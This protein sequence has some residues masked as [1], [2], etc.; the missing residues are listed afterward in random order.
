MLERADEDLI[1]GPQARAAPGLRD[2]VDRLGGAADKDD[3]ARAAGIDETPYALARALVRG[4]SRLTERMHAAMYVGVRVGLVVLDRAQ[5]RQRALRGCGA[6]QI[7]QRTPVHHGVED[8]KVATHALGVER[9]RRGEGGVCGPQADSAG[10]KGSGN[11]S[12]RRSSIWPRS[13]ANPILATTY[14]RNAH[15]S[16]RCATSGSSP[17]DSR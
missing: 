2:E 15:F 16:S 8:R 13:S 5:H 10:A 14:S 9:R 6:V 12:A 4:G 3:L 17:R 11:C 1:P 7:H